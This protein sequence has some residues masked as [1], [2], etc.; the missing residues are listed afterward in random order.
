MARH[1]ATQQPIYNPCL[2][3][4]PRVNIR[5]FLSVMGYQY[6]QW[7]QKF[8]HLTSS[9][10]IVICRSRFHDTFANSQHDAQVVCDRQG[11]E[12]VHFFF[13]FEEF[14]IIGRLDVDT[15][16]PAYWTSGQGW[17]GDFYWVFANGSSGQYIFFVCYNCFS[18]RCIAYR[19]ICSC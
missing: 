18:T 3:W 5:T 4:K 9:D 11:A 14:Y 6:H 15:A 17:G 12:L 16:Y 10:V 8:A 13:R 7:Q 1:S 19:L 2:H